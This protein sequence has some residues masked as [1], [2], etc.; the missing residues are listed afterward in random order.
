[1][2]SFLR[3]S[4]SFHPPITPFWRCSIPFGPHIVCPA[5]Y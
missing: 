1:M 4:M 5:K 3:S 2:S